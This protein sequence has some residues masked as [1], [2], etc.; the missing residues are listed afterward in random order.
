MMLINILLTNIGSHLFF[1]LLE[2]KIKNEIKTQIL[3]FDYR[4]TYLDLYFEY[5]EFID[6]NWENSHEFI[7]NNNIYDV[8][9][10]KFDLDKILVK[11]YLDHKETNLRKNYFQFLNNYLDN[12]EKSNNIIF[13]I[14]D[15]LLNKYIFAIPLYFN[16]N[17]F[18]NINRFIEIENIL[19]RFIEVRTPPP[20]N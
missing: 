6:L 2:K 5:E 10:I 7:L 15:L 11:C 13:N 1:K 9:I 4:I 16:D 12:K 19:N 18:V 8:K 14:L 17:Q 3:T 20:N